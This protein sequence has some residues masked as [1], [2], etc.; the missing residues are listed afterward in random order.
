MTPFDRIVQNCVGEANIAS[1]AFRFMALSQYG[2][3]QPIEV[4]HGRDQPSALRGRHVY[5]A[6]IADNRRRR[7]M[8]TFRSYR[9]LV[10]WIEWQ[11]EPS[12]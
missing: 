8:L 6:V 9:E 3:V 1:I 7:N 2:R 4:G 12:T 11:E 5:Y 10:A